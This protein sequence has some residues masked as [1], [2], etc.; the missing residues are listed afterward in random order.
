MC[1]LCNFRTQQL[2]DGEVAETP[3]R[4]ED[5]RAPEQPSP[6]PAEQPLRDTETVR[7]PNQATAI[8]KAPP[9]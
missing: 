8:F 1:W 5:K 2:V 6:D 9:K 7:T 4:F 3:F